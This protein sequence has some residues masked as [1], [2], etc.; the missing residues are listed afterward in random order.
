MLKPKH[1]NVMLCLTLSGVSK[2]STHYSG[3]SSAPPIITHSA[4]H[5]IQTDLH[6]ALIGNITSN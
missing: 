1:K 4:P 3:I 5:I 6:S 2:L